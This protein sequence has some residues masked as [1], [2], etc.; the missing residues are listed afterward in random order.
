MTIVI[1]TIKECEDWSRYYDTDGK[2]L[3]ERGFILD[4]ESLGKDWE[5]NYLEPDWYVED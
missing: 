1:K 3:A 2:G 5:D 4:Y